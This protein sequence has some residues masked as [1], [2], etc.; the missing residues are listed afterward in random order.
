MVE[1]LTGK[2]FG[3]L[4]VLEKSFKDQYRNI[5]WKCL[6]DC[7]NIT[8]PTSRALKSGGTKRCKECGN[9]ERGKQS[10]KNYE[11]LTGKRFGKLTVIKIVS[12]NPVKF[13]CRCDCGNVK[14]VRAKDLKQGK[15]KSC[16]CISKDGLHETHGKTHTRLYS[17]YNNMISRCENPNMKHYKHYGGKGVHICDTWR[18]DFMSFYEWAMKNGLTIDRIDANGNYEP[19]N[20]RWATQK[21]QANNTTRN[22]VIEYKGERK[23]LKQWAEFLEF[24]ESVLRSRLNH[25][26]SIEKAIETPKMNRGRQKRVQ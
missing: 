20:C 6:C 22:R 4:L 5:H 18:N 3:S 21:E 14:T 23:T 8:Y 13:E 26:W 9:L 25:G 15:T 24:D 10:E 7:G 19:S 1:D 17:I 2:K 11:D 12:H 16:G